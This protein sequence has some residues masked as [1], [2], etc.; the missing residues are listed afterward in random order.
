[1]SY[2]DPV[3]FTHGR[4]H[5]WDGL[6]LAYQL[7]DRPGA[8]TICLTNGLGGSYKAW[9][10]MVECLGSDHRLVSWDYRGLY[11]SDRP[12]DLSTLAVDKQCED[13]LRLFDHLDVDK[14]L[15]LGWSMGVQM[16]FEF[17]SRHPDRCWGIVAINGTSGRPFDTAMGPSAMR[18]ALPALATLL[19]YSGP[20]LGPVMG[21]VAS[22]W[23]SMKAT[24]LVGMLANTVDFHTWEDLAGDF[25]QLHLHTYFETLRQLNEHDAGDKLASIEVP[26]LVIGGQRDILTPGRVSRR[27]ASEVPHAEL[28]IVRGGTHY[29]PLEYPE[30]LALRVEKFIREQI[31]PAMAKDLASRRNKRSHP[32][33]GGRRASA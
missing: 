24:Q 27:I 11:R 14:A 28:L 20:V 25:A 4:F 26:L 23:I 31:E 29:V 3:G 15:L 9:A 18:K 17:Y 12:A 19:K 10:P 6:E 30:L 7:L 32:K 13:M 1:M 33:Q 16:N 2:A 21:K 5:S 22:R 8:P